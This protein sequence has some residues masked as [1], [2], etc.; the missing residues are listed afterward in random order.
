MIVKIGLVVIRARKIL[1]VRKQGLRELILP[2]GKPEGSETR[3]Q[4]LKREIREEL[5][6]G[7]KHPK[8]I[9]MFEEIAAG[10]KDK[11]RIFL[12]SG[13]ITGNPNPSGEIAALRW[14]GRKSRYS[15][16]PILKKRIIPFLIEKGLV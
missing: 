2:G 7:V 8:Y 10:R 11:V 12:Y 1:L 14:Y 4:C 13:K 15:L 16:S 9:G 3:I 5:D 6:V